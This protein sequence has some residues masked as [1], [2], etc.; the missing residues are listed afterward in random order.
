MG[1]EG[2]FSEEDTERSR[3]LVGDDQTAKRIMLILEQRDELLTRIQRRPPRGVIRR[4]G[5]ASA[6]ETSYMMPNRQVAGEASAVSTIQWRT[7]AT[8]ATTPGWVSASTGKPGK[9]SSRGASMC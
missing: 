1:L 3:K 4:E 2:E 5:R 9:P 7:S 6:I 8:F